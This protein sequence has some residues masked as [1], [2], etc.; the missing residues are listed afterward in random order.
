MW[1]LR[2]IIYKEIEDSFNIIKLILMSLLCLEGLKRN[3]L[4]LSIGLANCE[5][6]VHTAY[7]NQLSLEL[8]ILIIEVVG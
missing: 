2:V 3:K 7:V 6:F 5:G 8:I 1:I 4:T